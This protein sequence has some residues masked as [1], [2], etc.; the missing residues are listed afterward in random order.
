MA[1]EVRICNLALSRVGARRISSL[2]ENTKESRECNKI[3]TDT[4]DVVLAAHDWGFARK[5]KTLAA[6]AT[7]TYPGWDYAYAYPTD[8]L[9]ARR[10]KDDTGSVSQI[11]YDLEEERYRSVGKVE[12]EVR[13][14]EALDG[15]VILTDQADAVLIYTARVTDPNVFSIEFIDALAYR[16][17][18]DLAVPLRADTRKSDTHFRKYT[19]LIGSAQASSANE[20]YQKPDNGNSFVNARG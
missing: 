9:A 20:G 13:A 3:Y 2:S 16:L 19:F 7:P 14:T 17:A 5:H 8:C 4:R 11:A 6:I 12:F 15:K 1:S 18:S 10:I